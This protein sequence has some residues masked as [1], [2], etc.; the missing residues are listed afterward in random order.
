[1][2]TFGVSLLS[3]NDWHWKNEIV[4]VAMSHNHCEPGNSY[5]AMIVKLLAVSRLGAPAY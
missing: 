5:V 2:H 1:M 3:D 4:I